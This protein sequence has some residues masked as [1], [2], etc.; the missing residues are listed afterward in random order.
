MRGSAPA[1]VGQAAM[2]ETAGGTAA[3]SG[4]YRLWR[5][6]CSRRRCGGDGRNPLGGDVMQTAG[7]CP[8]T[9]VCSMADRAE[10]NRS[11][12]QDKA[13]PH[14]RWPMAKALAK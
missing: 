11:G 14:R 2:E 5:F 4:G 13:S 10:L 9:V 3:V 8:D 12:S 6:E 7:D 1:G